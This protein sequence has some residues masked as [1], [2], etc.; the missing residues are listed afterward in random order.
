MNFICFPVAGTNIFPIANSTTGGQLVT[1]WNLRSRES[2][3]TP[4][5]I[6]YLIGPSYTHSERD[7]YVRIQEDGAGTPISSTTLEILPG[8]CLLNGHFVESLTNIAIDLAEANSRAQNEQT[9]PLKGRLFIGLR[10]MYST[11][12]TLA[13]SLLVEN[14]DNMF[15]G[16]QVVILPPEQFILPEDSPTDESKVTAHIKLAEFY[17]VNGSINPST[18]INNYPGK[19]QYVDADRIGNVEGLLSDI[20]IRKT[21]L[22]PEKLYVFAGKGTDPATGLDTWCE[23]QDSLIIWDQNPTIQLE[24]PKLKQAVFDLNPITGET[25]LVL[26][27]KQVDQNTTTAGQ[28]KYYSPRTMNLPL[29][30]YN[31][32]TPGTI[33]GAYTRHIKEVQNSINNIYRMPAG[34]QRAFIDILTDRKDLPPINPAWNIGDYIIVRQD[35]TVTS[36]ITNDTTLVEAPSTMY[37]VIPGMIQQVTYNSSRTD[38]IIPDGLTGV[39]V[40]YM[41]L[42]AQN[43]D[44]PPNTDNAETYNE[45]WGMPSDTLRGQINVDYFVCNYYGLPEQED[46]DPPLT[47]YYYHVS[48]NSGANEYS[49]PVMVTGRIPFATEELVGGFLNVP[50]TAQDYGYVYLDSEGHLRLVDYAL[51]RSGTLA[52][53]LGQDYTFGSGLSTEEIQNQLDEYVNDRVAF[54][55]ENQLANADNPNVITITL[56]LPTEEEATTLYI[57]NIDSRFGTSINLR[58]IGTADSNTTI[59]ISDCQKIRIT[60]PISGTPV[61][62]LYRSCLYYDAN[63]IDYIRECTRDTNSYPSTFTGIQD[64]RLWYEQYSADEANLL[65]DDMTVMEVDAPIIPDEIDY[66]SEELPNDNH[67]MYALQSVTF[68]GNGDIIRCGLYVKNETTTNVMVGPSIIV[69]KF[70]LPQ[71]AGLNYPHTSLTKQLKV[72]GSFVVAY[73]TQSPI[74]YMVIDTNFTAMTNK[75]SIYDQTDVIDGQIAFFTNAQI[76]QNYGGVEGTPN[77]DAWSSNSF[78]T[79][80]GSVIG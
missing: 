60:N 34:K 58:I 64:F 76:V 18:V 22:N 72:T 66:W 40:G 51:L 32:E 43:N 3:A 19:C 30:D 4:Q 80:E 21:G 11:Q 78:H 31:A 9:Q 28:Q 5:E 45:M 12:Q 7:F 35:Q 55:N 10:A 41:D 52:Y 67:Y 54:P 17:Y 42:N 37:V 46:Q 70:S 36:E 65:V 57:R 38:N 68:S 20:Y 1:E 13:G 33:N 44:A 71:G 27:H 16:I 15:E 23:A 47:K 73:P 6:E 29:A 2:V 50:E 24:D 25:I 14:T 53:Q 63:I 69:S 8:R 77:I 48:Q 62:N 74:G 49:S 79:F 59:N 75:Y 56:E 39:Q 61:I 26:P